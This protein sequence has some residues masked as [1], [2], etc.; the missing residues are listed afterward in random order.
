MLKGV[1]SF[2]FPKLFP[3]GHIHSTAEGNEG[4]TTGTWDNQTSGNSFDR[5]INDPEASIEGGNIPLSK[6]KHSA[7]TMFYSKEDS[8]YGIPLDAITKTTDIHVEFGDEA[9][10]NSSGTLTYVGNEIIAYCGQDVVRVPLESRRTLPY[11]KWSCDWF[12]FP[13]WPGW[14]ITSILWASRVSDYHYPLVVYGEC[15]HYPLV[16]L[17]FK[18]VSLS[19][20]YET[21]F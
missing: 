13:S 9:A 5:W 20:R 6:L 11:H 17:R 7:P 8:K 16:F 19:L 12:W 18:S 4:Q 3:R 21:E 10:S 1:L 2:L 15:L 14:V